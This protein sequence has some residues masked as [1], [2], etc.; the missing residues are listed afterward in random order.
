ME[1]SQSHRSV[2]AVIATSSQCD[3]QPLAVSLA[4][5]SD[6]E[7]LAITLNATTTLDA[8]PARLVSEKLPNEINKDDLGSTR[9]PSTRSSSFCLAQKHGQ[10]NPSCFPHRQTQPPDSYA[11]L[12]RLHITNVKRLRLK[13]FAFFFHLEKDN[14]LVNL[15]RTGRAAYLHRF[16][17]GPK[18][19]YEGYKSTIS[20]LL[21]FMNM[22]Y[23]D[24]G[25]SYDKSFVEALERKFGIATMKS[26]T[27]SET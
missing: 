27:R 26:S 13:S 14:L 22:D 23:S 12:R 4:L 3:T 25:A 24:W 15:S 8:R 20:S 10:Q 21:G 11:K 9:R 1:T 19:P 5:P 16:N 18:D 2:R 17:L 6:E 7:Q